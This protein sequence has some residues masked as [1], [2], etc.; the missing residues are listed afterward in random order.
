MM[1][2][3]TEEEKSIQQV[4][5]ASLVDSKPIGISIENNAE[6][7]PSAQ[8]TTNGRMEDDTVLDLSGEE[9]EG[10]ID[11]AVRRSLEER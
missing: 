8:S 5:Q 10:M 1:L 7:P 4:I 11:E 2:S 9:D 6:P 3:S